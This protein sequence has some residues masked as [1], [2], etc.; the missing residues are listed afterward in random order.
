MRREVDTGFVATKQL[1]LTPS[2]SLRS[3]LDFVL[4]VYNPL[5]AFLPPPQE[6]LEEKYHEELN[7]NFG[8]TFNNLYTM[9]NMPVK[10][11]NCEER[12]DELRIQ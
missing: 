3:S 5:G 2:S 9:T 1:I 8:I 11:S 10:V 6:A 12:S 4:A 7:E